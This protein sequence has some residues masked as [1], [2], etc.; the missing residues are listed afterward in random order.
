MHQNKFKELPMRLAC[1]AVLVLLAASQ[2]K[3]SDDKDASVY[4]G[5]IYPIT[6]ENCGLNFT[7]N[8]PPQRVVTLHQVPSS[9]KC[10]TSFF[11]IKNLL[12]SL[13]F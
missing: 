6:I 10:V 13:F 1:I 11:F 5:T 9:S 12:P 8:A 7:Y 3:A 4:G 2:I